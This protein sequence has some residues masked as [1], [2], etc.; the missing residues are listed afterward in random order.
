MRRSA[1]LALRY[2]K[3]TLHDSSV[4]GEASLAFLHCRIFGRKTGFHLRLR[5]GGHFP[6]LK[7]PPVVVLAKLPML[8]KFTVL[9]EIIAI[10]ELTM[11][12][13]LIAVAEIIPVA[14]A[15]V[16]PADRSA[17]TETGPIAVTAPVP[18]GASPSVVDPAIV[19]A[20]PAE[21]GLLGNRAVFGS[22]P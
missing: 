6:A 22:R 5:E 18:A 19:V 1:C 8:A 20:A 12:T 16:V 11:L 15:P 4:R 17:P 7:S 2:G 14:K 9:A 10:T 3:G 13:E 21:L